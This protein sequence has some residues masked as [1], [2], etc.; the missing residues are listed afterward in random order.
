[1]GGDRKVIDDTRIITIGLVI[2]TRTATPAVVSAPD[3]ARPGVDQSCAGHH[4][5][6][7]QA[8]LV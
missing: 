7:E 5:V 4:M 6:T 2:E 3:G 1:M 8:N